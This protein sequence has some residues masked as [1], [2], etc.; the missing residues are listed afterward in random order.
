M[1]KLTYPKFTGL[2]LGQSVCKCRSKHQIL[3]DLANTSI[4]KGH[5]KFKDTIDILAC[6]LNNLAIT[7]VYNDE[8][9]KIMAPAY[10]ELRTHTKHTA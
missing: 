4:S 9:K 3:P 7:N 6:G 8:K 5:I 2:Q 1:H 10:K